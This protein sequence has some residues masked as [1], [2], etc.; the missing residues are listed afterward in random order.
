MSSVQLATLALVL[1]PIF[2]TATVFLLRR[3]MQRV[4]QKLDILLDP[5][6]GVFVRLA[7]IEGPADEYPGPRNRRSSDRGEH[8]TER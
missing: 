6:T 8:G 4:E 2:F 3:W 5:H 1:L 7:R